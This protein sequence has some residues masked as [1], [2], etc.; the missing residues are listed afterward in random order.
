MDNELLLM[1]RIEVIKVVNK[2]YDLENNGYIAFSGGKDSTILHYL[3][4]LALP[5]NNIPRVYIDT[6]IEYQM[7]KDFVYNLQKSDKRFQIVKPSVPIKK[8]LEKDG[9][10]FK[11]KEFSKLVKTYKNNH[12]TIDNF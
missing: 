3:I 10:P 5:N 6:G 12:E 7:I 2:K 8:M 4:D 9:Y 1:D 11:S